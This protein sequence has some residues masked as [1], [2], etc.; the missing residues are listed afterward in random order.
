MKVSSQYIQTENEELRVVV[1]VLLTFHQFQTT[2]ST[3]N[4]YHLLQD[5]AVLYEEKLS[6]P[7]SS[8]TTQYSQ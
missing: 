1:N 8:I 6:I 7:V 4:M 5:M 2:V 3:P